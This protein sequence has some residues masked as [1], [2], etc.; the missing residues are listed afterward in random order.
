MTGDVLWDTYADALIDC[1]IEGSRRLLRGPGAGPLPVL[2]TFVL[3]AYNPQGVEREQA[4]NEADEEQ[5][6]RELAASGVTFWPANGW[7]RD[8]SWSEPG[9]ALSGCGRAVAC[10]LG[11]RYGQLAV[12]EL[13]ADTVHVVRCADHEVVRTRPRSE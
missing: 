1:E 10:E 5:L 7:S 2:P 9:V 3:T 6:E 4:R 8:A 11:R 13:T 12:Y